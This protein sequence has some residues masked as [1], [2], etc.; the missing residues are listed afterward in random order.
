MGRRAGDSLTSTTDAVEGSRERTLT[1]AKQS[2]ALKYLIEQEFRKIEDATIIKR[3]AFRLTAILAD[4]YPPKVED[5]QVRGIIRELTVDGRPP[6]GAAVR[7]A[8]ESRYRSRGGVRR[9]YRLLAS[10]RPREV[11]TSPSPVGMGLLELENRNLREQLKHARQ[12]ED[13]HQVYWNREVGQLRAGVR[14]LESLVQ[15]AASGDISEALSKEVQAAETRAGQL[16]VQ[17]R[18]F[19]PAAGRA[20][21]SG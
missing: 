15:Q 10:E 16:E 1:Y 2:R 12:R 7:A 11:T 14:A 17:V 13:A 8:L 19:G 4:M 21:S 5:E 9:I 3:K 6:S 18:V 20:R